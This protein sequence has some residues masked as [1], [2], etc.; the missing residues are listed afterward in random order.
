[1]RIACISSWNA[2]CGVATH[3]ELL[4]AGL[5]E[6]GHQVWV[7]AP[8]S[9]EDDSTRL[10]HAPDGPNVYR[11]FSFL[12]YGDREEDEALLEALYFDS[13]ALL[14]VDPDLVVVEKPTSTP[15]PA[16]QTALAE[17]R[18][19]GRLA[20]ILHEGTRPLNP[21]LG[22]LKWDLAAVFDE[23][24]PPLFHA[25]IPQDRLIVL[26]FPCHPPHRGPQGKAREA[27]GLPQDATIALTYG[28]RRETLEASHAL[29]RVEGLL[30][31][32]LVGTP[33]AYRDLKP[34]EWVK[35]VYLRPPTPRLYQYLWASD[36]LILH[37]PQPPHIALSA[38]AHLCLGSLTPLVCSHTSYFQ[39]LGPEAAKYRGLQELPKALQWATGPG[40]EGLTEA[41]KA[42]AE[43]RDPTHI[44]A[45]LLEA[46]E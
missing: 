35:P 20:A 1:M 19:D 42:Y 14:E 44:A 2:A 16:I 33:Q 32:A 25:I 21:Y 7:L 46:L 34:L 39:G 3:A 30:H 28:P 15:L 31:L 43:A 24:Y 26:P 12:R 17:S 13:Q 40:R 4:V 41:A 22:R 18:F 37:R 38:S 45:L 29:G 27:L 9:Y 36:A 23:R 5:R 6:L 8:S 10:L 11:C